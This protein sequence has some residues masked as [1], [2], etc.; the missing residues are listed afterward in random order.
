[1]HRKIYIENM[2]LEEARQLWMNHLDSMGFC[3]PPV[4]DIKTE[5]AL[6]RISSK[7]IHA[8]RSSPHYQAAAMDGIAVRAAITF[9]A[10]ERSPVIISPDQYLEVD[11]G[12]YV[13]NDYDAVIMI[14]DVNFENDYATIIN[15]AV[16][17]Q[18]IRSI[19]EDMVAQ[20]LIIPSYIRIG[21]FEQA[22]LI[23]AGVDEIEVV[24]QPVIAIIPTGTEL[25]DYGTDSMAPGEIV[26]SNSHMLSALCQ[27]WGAIPFRHSIVRDDRDQIK[28]AI[29]EMIDQADMIIVCSGSSA[30]REDYTSAIIDEL[31]QLL[32]HGLA[33]RPGKPAILGSIQGKPVIGVPGYPISAQLVFHLFARPALYARQGLSEPDEPSLECQVARKLPSPMGV[34][35]YVYVNCAQID[36]RYYAYPLNRGAGVT[37]SLVKADGFIRIPRGVEGVEAGE[38]T[39]VFIHRS[40]PT[41]DNT[42]VCIGSHD[43]A[44]DVLADLLQHHHGIRLI[45]SNVGSMGGIMSLRRQETHMA[46]IHLLDPQ[47]GD[48][49]ISYLRRY[50]PDIKWQ[51]LTLVKRRQGLIVKPGNPLHIEELTDLTRSEVRFINRQKGSGTRVLFDYLLNK[52]HLNNED[53]YGYNHEEYTHLAVAA[54]VKNDACDVGMGVFASARVLGLDFIPIIEENYELCILPDIIK[55]AYLQLLIDIIKS[56]EFAER[57]ASLGGY[58]L[59]GSGEIRLISV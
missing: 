28:K 22:C 49:N 55:P 10:T 30:G 4:E 31:G 33:I 32:V 20:D 24:K 19:G 12:D 27:Q 48:Y 23:T 39:Q 18:H 46:G 52:Q 7:A 38:Q 16:P 1:M 17:W 37:S 26:E 5:S 29:L 58:N 54:A 21:P 13:P 15:P 57:V 40:R 41:I 51:L 50:L 6:N 44:I 3:T 14:E 11:T 25:V 36:D 8:Q 43:L 2:P 34:D 47:T 45:S 42:L 35:E 53:I 59:D 9:G 56:Q